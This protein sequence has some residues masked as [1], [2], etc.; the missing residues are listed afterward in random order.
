MRFRSLVPVIACCAVSLAC[1][2]QSAPTPQSIEAQLKGP[3]LMLRGMYHGNK[4]Q[5]DAQGDLIGAV[6]W[7]DPF[8]MSAVQVKKV[9]LDPAGVRLECD[10]E[11]LI[12]PDARLKV[13]KEGGKVTVEIARDPKHPEELQAA[14]ARVFSVGFDDALLSELPPL[15]Q[16]WLRRQLNEQTEEALP[17]RVYDLNGPYGPI[18]PPKLI[19]TSLS[20]P[21]TEAARAHHLGGI[22]VLGLVV[23]TDG[24]PEDIHVLVALGLGLDEEAAESLAQWRFTPGM[25]QGRPVPVQI[26]IEMNFRMF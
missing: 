7:K 22:V 3:F 26:N 25:Y 4:L 13:V 1:A 6:K 10:R 14:L 24:H 9:T 20:P 18:K 12:F 23:D 16:P 19:G 15:W 17:A 21:M 5:Y 8:L 11:A 2:A